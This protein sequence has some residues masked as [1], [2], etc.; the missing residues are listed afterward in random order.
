MDLTSKLSAWWSA[1]QERCVETRHSVH[2]DQHGVVQTVAFANNETQ[3]RLAGSQITSVYAY[4][5]DCFAVD[6]IR[7]ILGAEIQQTWIEVTENDSGYKQ[8]VTDLAHHLPDCPTE[9]EW[10]QSVALPPFDKKWTLLY[11]R[12]AEADEWFKTR[13]AL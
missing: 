10:S 4:K 13:D 7:I 1:I 5:Q 11:G 9:A 12:T 8:L 2:C 6:Q 3:V